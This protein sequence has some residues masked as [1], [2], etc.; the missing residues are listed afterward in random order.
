VR[1]YARPFSTPILKRKLARVKLRVLEIGALLAEL[2]GLAAT[3]AM[4]RALLVDELRAL[5]AHVRANIVLQ[6][7]NRCRIGARPRR[8]H[9]PHPFAPTLRYGRRR[10]SAYRCVAHAAFKHSNLASR[11]PEKLMA[12][13]TAAIDG[14]PRLIEA[15]LR[16]WRRGFKPLHPTLAYP[17]A[18]ALPAS[19]AP[20]AVVA[21]DTS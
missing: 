11:D 6:A 7:L 19:P 3:A 20:R 13:I 8:A 18:Q 16:R 17:T 9:E 2:A 12:A 21:A 5:A 1:I 14:A 10:A 15:L 4:L